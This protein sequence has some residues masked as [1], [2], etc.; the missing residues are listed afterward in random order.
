MR[1]LPLVLAHAAHHRGRTLLLVGCVAVAMVVPLLSRVLVARFEANLHARADTVPLV[2]GAKGSRF[3]LVF[4][5]L[6]FREADLAATPH[7]VYAS[8]VADEQAT[9]IPVHAEFA[10]E[11]VP[12]V[13]TSIEYL[14]ARGLRIAEGR[15]FARI[16]EVV[17]GADAAARLGVAPG[18]S[19]FSDQREAYDITSP[20]SVKLDVAGVLAPTGGVDDGVI[21]ADLETAWV[22][23]GI[24]HGHAEAESIDREDLVLGATEDH[25]ALS[26]AVSTYQEITDETAASFH[27]HGPRD[28]LPLTAVLV[29]PRDDKARTILASRLNATPDLQA[30]RPSRVI[31]DLV[32]FVV[33]LRQIFDALAVL[34]A[35]STAALIVL[36]GVL[37]YRLRADEIRTLTDIGCGRATVGL[38][39]GLELAFVLLAAAVLA[40]VLALA[41]VSVVAG[42]TPYL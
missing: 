29:Y 20:P 38:L 37:S 30:V 11:G 36:I 8:L 13:A 34:L 19:V 6:Y 33:R 28:N 16:G 41:V 40:G 26:G 2:V 12:V 23:E 24:A 1:L 5:A 42:V 21:L 7:R 18:G 17:L 3:D 32:A 22:L 9:A 15:A 14:Q 4:A 35:A 10:A 39:F 27:V 25:V 31:D